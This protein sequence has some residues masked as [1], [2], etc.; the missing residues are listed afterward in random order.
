MML[1]RYKIVVKLIVVSEDNKNL[2]LLL[3]F[4]GKP[5]PALYHLI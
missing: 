2:L 4:T 3:L 1:S 5:W